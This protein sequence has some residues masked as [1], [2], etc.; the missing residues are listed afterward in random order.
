M[1]SHTLLYARKPF[2]H[3]ARQVAGAVQ[4][5]CSLLLRFFLKS[6]SPLPASAAPHKPSSSLLDP[7]LCLPHN[8]C[9]LGGSCFHTD[10][11]SNLLPPPLHYHL[12]YLSPSPVLLA[13]RSSGPDQGSASFRIL[14]GASHTALSRS[15]FLSLTVA[16]SCYR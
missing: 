16:R 15:G 13:L 1:A 9:L 7:R 14:P 10:H 5:K 2:P 4:K 12:S 6:Q 8:L 3:W 11:T